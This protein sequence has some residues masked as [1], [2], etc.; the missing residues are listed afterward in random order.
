MIFDFT[1]LERPNRIY[2]I[3]PEI[4]ISYN[5][6]DRRIYGSDTTAI[7]IGRVNRTFLI[8]NGN[9]VESLKSLSVEDAIEYFYSHPDDWNYRFTEDLNIVQ[10]TW[11][12]VKKLG[13]VLGNQEQDEN[14]MIDEFPIWVEIIVG[15]L[16]S[17]WELHPHKILRVKVPDRQIEI[18]EALQALDFE[19]V[20]ELMK[21]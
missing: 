4:Y 18:R 9:H 20:K 12:D 17:R 7:V 19:L 3:N 8:L 13:E 5:S 6:V 2:P 15:S 16:S 14:A 1:Q 10:M 11:K 21:R